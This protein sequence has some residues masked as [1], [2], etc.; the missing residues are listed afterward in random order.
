MDSHPGSKGMKLSGA[1]RRGACLQILRFVL[2]ATHPSSSEVSYGKD[3]E[4][5]THATL[6]LLRLLE[7]EVSFS[8]P[9][10]P[11]PS[12]LRRRTRGKVPPGTRLVRSKSPGM[13]S[14]VSYKSL[15]KRAHCSPF[16][17]W[18]NLYRST[19]ACTKCE[20]FVKQTSHLACQCKET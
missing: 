12:E 14:L 2:R 3:Q 11:P 20:C 19:H 10:S 1:A 4:S 6:I 13:A 15:Q 18:L 17:C 16:R 5:K 9:K 7:N 8:G